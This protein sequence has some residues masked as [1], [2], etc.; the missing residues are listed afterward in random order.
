MNSVSVTILTKNSGRF[1]G[2]C[3]D[4]LRLFEEIIVLDNGS[5]DNTL[6][7]A[8]RYPN[9]KV[10]EHEFIGFG[11]LKNMAAA[12][13]GN[14]WIFN[15][16]SDE[17]VSPGLAQDVLNRVLDSKTVYKLSRINH[18]NGKRIRGCGW[19]GDTK[20]RLYDRRITSFS[21]ILVHEKV[22]VRDNMRE[23]MLSGPLLHYGFNSIAQLLDKLQHYS[24][25]SAD[26][27]S[28]KKRSNPLKAVLHGFWHFIRTYLIKYGFIDGAEGFLISVTAANQVFYK[29]MKIWEK[30]KNREQ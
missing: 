24:E 1:I 19:S 20:H 21:D 22:I 10:I 12:A 28:T 4:A 13:A 23:G 9:V 26:Q 8:R 7:I 5:T 18:Y 25:L 27:L 3:L 2:K 30:N 29:H 11:P 17:V 16:D 15:I 14:D 6:D